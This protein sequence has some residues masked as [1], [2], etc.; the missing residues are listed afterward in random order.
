MIHVQ[1]LKNTFDDLARRLDAGAER[2]VDNVADQVA[3]GMKARTSSRIGRTIE[4]HR[5]GDAEVTVVAG[6]LSSAHHAGFFEFGTVDRP[7][8]PFVVPA[9]EEARHR[10]A[11]AVARVLED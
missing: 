11:A 2:V 10:F 9:A 5:T 3:A 6:D 8:E 1:V 7:A 4:T